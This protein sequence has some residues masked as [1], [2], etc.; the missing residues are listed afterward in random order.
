MV[1]TDIIMPGGKSGLQLASEV[2]SVRPDIK[3]LLTSGYPGRAIAEQAASVEFPIVPK[4]FRQAD[5]AQRL[6]AVLDGV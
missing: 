4:P 2:K 3:V 5:L 1:F 6:R